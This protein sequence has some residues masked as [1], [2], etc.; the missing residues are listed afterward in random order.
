MPEANGVTGVHEAGAWVEPRFSDPSQ[1]ERTK[2]ETLEWRIKVL[3]PCFWIYPYFWFPN[4][5]LFHVLK[6]W[7]SSVRGG[8]KI[9]AMP[10]SALA[11]A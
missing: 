2:V 9:Q 10:G 11:T 4:F 8:P 7:P 5:P 6:V 3:L 1:G